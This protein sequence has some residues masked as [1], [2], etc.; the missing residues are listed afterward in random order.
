M[1]TYPFLEN[2][3]LCENVCGQTP[4]QNEARLIISASFLGAW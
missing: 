1:G 4:I 2:S 3:W